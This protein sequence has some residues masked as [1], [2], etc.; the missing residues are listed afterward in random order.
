MRILAESTGGPLDEQDRDYK[1]VYCTGCVFVRVLASVSCTR[2]ALISPFS[3]PWNLG[4]C[5]VAICR[6]PVDIGEGAVMGERER[7]LV[8]ESAGGGE[9]PDPSRHHLCISARNH[10]PQTWGFI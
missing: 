8:R 5:C 1:Q 6:E 2:V 7:V 9:G 10:M 3:E 4:F